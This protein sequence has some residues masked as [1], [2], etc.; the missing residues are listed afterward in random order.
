[1]CSENYDGSS[2]GMEATGAEEV[3]L[4]FFG[5][6]KTGSYIKMLLMDLTIL[7]QNRSWSTRLASLSNLGISKNGPRTRTVKG[8]RERKRATGFYLL[9]TLKLNF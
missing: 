9:T 4:D 3:V 8:K 7:R 2:K 6:E 5:H 1:M